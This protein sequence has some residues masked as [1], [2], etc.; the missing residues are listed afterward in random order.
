MV[1]YTKKRSVKRRSTKRI[2][3]RKPNMVSTI[4]KIVNK[5]IL[6]KAE[7]K[8]NTQIYGTLGTTQLYHNSMQYNVLNG[9]NNMPVQG[10][11]DLTRIGDKINVGGFYIRMLCAH[12]NDRPNL[13]WKFYVVSAP[14]GTGVTYNKFFDNVSG[15]ILL[16]NPNKDCIK[17]LKSITRKCTQGNPSLVIGAGHIQREVTFPVKIWLPYKKTYSFLTDN[18]TDHNDRDLY[19]ITFVYDTIGAL[20]TDN[21]ASIQIISSMYYKDP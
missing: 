10:T 4:S 7:P 2:V 9:T 18:S 1:K 20:V 16:D 13:T 5:V 8:M 6:K 12:K 3:T 15:N 14:K 19:L 17:V 21:V 11:T